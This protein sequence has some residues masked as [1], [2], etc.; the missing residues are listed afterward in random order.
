M[1]SNIQSYL[2]KHGFAQ[3]LPKAVL[4]DMDGVLYNSMPHH[5]ICWHEAMA[6]FDLK[7]SAT[8][9]YLTEGMRGVETIQQMMREQKQREVTEEEAQKMYDEKARLFS[10]LPPSPK[11]EGIME[12][13]EQLHRDN[14]TVVVVTGSGQ[15]PLIRKLLTDFSPFI[16]ENR[17]VTA[18]DVKRGK[19]NAEP[20]LMGLQKAGNLQ[21]FE[22]IVVENAPMGVKAGVAAAIFTIGVNTG[23]LPDKALQ[24][25]GANMVL[26]NMNTLLQTWKEVFRPLIVK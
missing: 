17:I 15:K 1:N 7:M 10:L 14:I 8:D 4:F 9:A 3:L 19:P 22:A 13:M 21:P 2:S 25:Q 20:Y 23:I 16:T 26:P 11:V 5:A 18:Y 12:V 24:E 6:K